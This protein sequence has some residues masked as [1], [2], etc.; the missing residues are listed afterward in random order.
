VGTIQPSWF[1]DDAGSKVFVISTG[2]Q[3]RIITNAGVITNLVN[4]TESGF[5]TKDGTAAIYRTTAG[6]LEKHTGTGGPTALVATGVMGFLG[7]SPDGK[8][9]GYYT[10]ENQQ[11][12]LVDARSVDH[13]VTPAPITYVATPTSQPLGFNGDGS[14]FV[15]VDSADSKMKSK[16]AAGGNETVVAEDIVAA[17]IAPSGPGA[18][19]Y[20]NPD[21]QALQQGLLIA[22]IAYIDTTSADAPKP[23][24]MQIPEPTVRIK[25]K[26][27]VYAKIGAM[28]GLFKVSLP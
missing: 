6:A 9:I 2:G 14:A 7:D 22:D 4:N 16:P 20:T 25:D 1:A 24:A 12:G 21:M 19:V 3:G 5:M 23:I 11:E 18:I 17:E 13:T 15:Y 28:A 10:Q 8:R 26:T 27:L